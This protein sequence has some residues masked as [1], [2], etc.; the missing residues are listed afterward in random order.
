MCLNVFTTC[1]LLFWTLIYHH[2]FQNKVNFSCIKIFSGLLKGVR[3]RKKRH[4]DDQKNGWLLT[5]CC[6]YLLIKFNWFA[7]DW[8]QLIHVAAIDCAEERNL[9]ICVHYN[10][11]GYPSVKVCATEYLNVAG[12]WSIDHVY[13]LITPICFS[14]EQFFNASAPISNLGETYIGMHYE[15]WLWILIVLLPVC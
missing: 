1:H 13:I 15:N 6:S 14:L 4:W 11:E 8:R 12:T 10:I 7:S 5:H 3:P 9:P 2:I